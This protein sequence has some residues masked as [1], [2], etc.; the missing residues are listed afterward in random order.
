MS[1]LNQMRKSPA[2]TAAGFLFIVALIVLIGWLI[3]RGSKGAAGPSGG[4]QG[5]PQIILNKT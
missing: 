5:K 1:I 2:M 3:T 4:A